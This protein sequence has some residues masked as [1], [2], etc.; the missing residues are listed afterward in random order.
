[1]PPNDH[2][3]VGLSMRQYLQACRQFVSCQ[4]TSLKPGHDYQIIL[5][6]PQRQYESG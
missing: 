5:L 6:L 3:V 2:F 4:I 1:M